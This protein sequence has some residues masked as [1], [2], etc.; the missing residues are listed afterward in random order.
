MAVSIGGSTFLGADFVRMGL[1]ALGAAEKTSEGILRKFGQALSQTL[2]QHLPSRQKLAK[3]SL[4]KVEL[5]DHV[6]ELFLSLGN[7]DEQDM[8]DAITDLLYFVIDILQFS[9]ERNAYDEIDFDTI[10]V[11]VLDSLRSCHGLIQNDLNSL[12]G[13]TILIVDKEL[14][15]IPWESLPCMQT[16]SVSRMPSLSAV[17]ERLKKIREQDISEAGYSLSTAH[18][19]YMLNPSSDLVSTQSVFQPVLQTHLPDYTA[20][21]NI[22]PTESEFE[23]TLYENDLFLY[24]GHGAGAQY[25]RGR[26]IRSL[27]KCA[28]TLLMGCSS[29]KMTECGKL[30]SYGM[31]G[32]YINGLSG[33]MAVVG[34]LWDVT[35][36]DIDRFALRLMVEWGLIPEDELVSKALEK[37]RKKGQTKST[38][39]NKGESGGEQGMK[40][41]RGKVGLDEAVRRG[42]E[43]CAL[44]YLNGAAPVVYGVPVFLG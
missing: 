25:I 20:K 18:G 28:V 38:N 1:R 16:Q 10:L 41:R 15:S 5:H 31:P 26:K 7:P 3:N 32:Y 23:A 30:E 40:E 17:L 39:V 21:I 35:D 29:A 9:G 36:R 13:H 19:A 4:A 42:R 8:D 44:K 34:T 24:F 33:C 27:D 12:P 37:P 11:E 22:A 43:A 14:A 6:L 2:D